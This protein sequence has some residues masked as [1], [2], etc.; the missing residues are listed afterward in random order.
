VDV[1]LSWVV[2]E[3]LQSRDSAWRRGGGV[4]GVKGLEL[5]VSGSVGEIGSGVVMVWVGLS[6]QWFDRLLGLVGAC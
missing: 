3:L 4:C 1:K 5:V 2:V 6:Q